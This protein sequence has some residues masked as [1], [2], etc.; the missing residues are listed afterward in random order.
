MHADSVT[1]PPNILQPEFTG[2][3]D[4]IDTEDIFAPKLSRRSMWIEGF[5]VMERPPDQLAC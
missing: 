2:N 5:P 4:H 3:A 1:L